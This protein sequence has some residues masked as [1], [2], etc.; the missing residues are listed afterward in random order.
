MYSA[1]KLNKQ[2]D[3]IKWGKLLCEGKLE[4]DHKESWT[5]NNWCFWIVVLEKTLESPLDCKEIKTVNPK[6][7]Q[8]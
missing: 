2:G 6:K 4:F 5:L 8:S 7:Y 1:Y 3:N